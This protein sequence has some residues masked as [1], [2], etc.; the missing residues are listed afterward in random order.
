M[1]DAVQRLPPPPALPRPPVPAGFPFIAVIAPLVA[2][3]VIGLITGSAFV[4]VFA[5]LSPL[6][7]IATVVDGRRV[8]RRHRT[9]E[10][11]RFDQ[12]C[13]AF[14][15]AITLTH[16]DERARA[17]IEHP[18]LPASPGVPPRSGV[19]IGVAP[20][21]SACA[22]ERPLIV[23]EGEHER[24]LRDL[25]DR[26][27]R[28]PALPLIAP[29]GAIGVRGSGAAADGLFV[30]LELEP[31]C[32]VRRLVAEEPAR[33]GE[34]VVEVRSV[35]RVRLHLPD[36]RTID[37]TPEF[38]SRRDRTALL[39]DPAALQPPLRIAWSALPS[40]ASPATGSPES[41]GADERGHAVI[42]G[43]DGT[44]PAALDIVR[45]GPHLLVGGTTGSGKS[46]F[47]R[48]LALGWAQRFSPSEVHLLLVDFKGGATFA[49]LSDLPHTVGV[50][51]D[52]DPVIAERTLL[53]MRAELQRR[54]RLLVEQGVRDA[55]EVP[56]LMARLVV[57][58]D[59]FAT[60]I[61][62]FPLLQAAFADLAARGRSLGVHLVLGTQHP[63]VAVR[64]AVAANCAMRVAFRLPESAGA[65]FLGSSGRSLTAVP[66][67][68][69]TIVTAEGD[70]RIQI[71][72][73]DD[74]DVAAVRARWAGHP[75]AEGPW[76]PPLPPVITAADV[77]AMLG[78]VGAVSSAHGASGGSVFGIVDDPGALCRTAAR[79]QAGA[80]GPIV[81]IGSPGSGR[82]TALAALAAGSGAES[83]QIVA[84]PVDVPAAWTALE[85]IAEGESPCELLVADD[86]D[87][88]V[89]A[90]AELGPELLAL[91][92]AAV[93]R[94]RRAGGGVAAAVGPATVARPMLGARFPHRLVLRA[95]DAEDHALAGGPRGLFD[96]RAVPGRGWWLDQQVQ[97]IAD[98]PPLPPASCDAP[99]W[100]PDPM[101]GVAVVARRPAQVAAALAAAMPARE[102]IRAAP[103]LLVPGL[104]PEE[105]RVAEPIAVGHPDDWQGSW[106]VLTQLRRSRP[107]LVVGGD[108]A[109]LRALLAIRATPP[110][111]DP[112]RGEA[113]LVEPGGGVARVRV[114]ALVAR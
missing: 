46:E 5:I 47:L 67:G 64:D 86:L 107:V 2:A 39:V 50:I 111:I 72:V 103:D 40:P 33:P 112:D 88:L 105:A 19:R 32:T 18:L 7:A 23:G 82:T 71:A 75:L 22:P 24:R 66:A 53:G 34:T 41:L 73:T 70:R 1:L 90:A 57:L 13:E 20:G 78:A 52:L 102:V 29:R 62:D 58:V 56:H 45:E 80:D 84:L 15:R 99:V 81:V 94:I 26:A 65:A 16:H 60:L 98:Q 91:W 76:L 93:R 35:R 37:G 55:S 12:E 38:L 96:R 42:V 30:R 28:H 6:I 108:A 48:T 61:D 79:W 49:G 101:A 51:T 27:S 31:G 74:A 69:A 17:D 114:D 68:R 100:Q 44:G 106:S 97:V 89:T 110:P 92:D 113:W 54:E 14:D 8:A 10:S 43:H 11:D 87:L 95:L 77:P 83:A 4:L 85:R 3:V 21:L 109:D 104:V 9:A 63:A 59:E 25:L 36:A